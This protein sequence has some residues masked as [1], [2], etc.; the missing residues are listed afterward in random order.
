[1]QNVPIH[2]GHAQ[3]EAVRLHASQGSWV[4]G[5]ILLEMTVSITNII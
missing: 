1:M 3:P 2:K 4:C 5:S